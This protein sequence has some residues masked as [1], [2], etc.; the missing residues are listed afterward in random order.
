[1]D[2]FCVVFLEGTEAVRRKT[3]EI[4]K[5][6]G[7]GGNLIV[8]VTEDMLVEHRLTELSAVTDVLREHGTYSP[9]SVPQ[10]KSSR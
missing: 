7:C 2:G 8:T 5:E 9:S 1:M 6:A 4:L 10:R 3:L